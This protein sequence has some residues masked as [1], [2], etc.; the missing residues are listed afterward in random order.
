MRLGIAA[1]VTLS[2]AL[3]SAA[4]R[5]NLRSR[6]SRYR[7]PPAVPAAPAQPPAVKAG[8]TCRT[9]ARPKARISTKDRDSCSCRR[10]TE[11]PDGRDGK[12]R[13]SKLGL[14]GTVVTADWF[15]ALNAPKGLRSFGGTLWDG[16]PRRSDRHRHRVRPRRTRASRSTARSSSTTWRSAP[17]ARF[18]CPTCWPARSTRSRTARRRSSP[19]GSSSS[20]RTVFSLTASGLSSAGGAARRRPTSA[21]K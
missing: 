2:L 9:C 17:T 8:W 11:R 21:P 5:R 15:T 20:I 4:E 13:I 7:R 14:D 18:T 16:R 10:L 12:G 19:K 1:P 3:A 6:H